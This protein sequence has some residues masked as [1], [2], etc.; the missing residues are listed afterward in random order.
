MRLIITEIDLISSF[1]L[2]KW[3]AALKAQSEACIVVKS[4]I[5]EHFLTN[6]SEIL[7]YY[8]INCTTHSYVYNPFS[9]LYFDYL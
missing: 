3:T 5:P 6:I 2:E 7:D 4:V 1:S 8:L 9:V